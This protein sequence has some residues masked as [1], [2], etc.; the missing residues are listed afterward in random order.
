MYKQT[1][2][3]LFCWSVLTASWSDDIAMII[4]LW[5]VIRGFSM[6]STWV[7][8]YKVT[9]K[10]KTQ[11]LLERHY[12]DFRYLLTIACILNVLFFSCSDFKMICAAWKTRC[13]EHFNGFYLGCTTTISANCLCFQSPTILSPIKSNEKT[14][15]SSY[16][17][18]VLCVKTSRLENKT[19]QY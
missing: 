11:K 8:Y 3:I 18:I 15:M 6:A 10:K 7:E 5:I 2:D 9:Q 16:I 14:N 17:V 19:V 12:P 1:D 4:D 13:K